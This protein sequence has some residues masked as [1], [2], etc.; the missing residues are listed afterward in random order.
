MKREHYEFDVLYVLQH[1][2]Q[3]ESIKEHLTLTEIKSEP[4]VPM[5]DIQECH[6]PLEKLDIKPSVDVQPANAKKVPT[7]RG[8]YRKQIKTEQ[9]V[10]NKPLP[11]RLRRKKAV[12]YFDGYEYRKP[13]TCHDGSTQWECCKISCPAT[14]Q[15]KPDGKLKLIAKHQ[16]HP[17]Q[18]VDEGMILDRKM[19]KRVPFLVTNNN[20]RKKFIYNDSFRYQFSQKLSNG[21]MIWNCENQQESCKAYVR[22]TEDFRCVT[23]IFQHNH[24]A[25]MV[26]RRRI[27]N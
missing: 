27:V 24:S 18:V 10:K 9:T 1:L 8:K 5:N 12:L 6:V 23:P 19:R 7:P 3:N 11:P 25:E 22:I 17:Q 20:H 14:L 4:P 13:R 16:Q 26:V 15:Q 21:Q 2:L